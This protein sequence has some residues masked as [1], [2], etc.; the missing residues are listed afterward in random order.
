M[1]S[2]QD[3]RSL[4]RSF[5][6]VKRG[7]TDS[8]LVNLDIVRAKRA[9]IFNRHLD[10]F[11][12]SD[13]EEINPS[14]RKKRSTEIDVEEG[15]EAFDQILSE[16]VYTESDCSNDEN[17]PVRFNISLLDLFSKKQVANKEDSLFVAVSSSLFGNEMYSNDIREETRMYIQE[18]K[19][20]F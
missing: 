15:K 14:P 6:R 9:E 18:N 2:N 4:S 17:L 12:F 13:S 1:E 11:N 20:R 19:H 3:C 10:S 7:T 16:E 8:K 5:K